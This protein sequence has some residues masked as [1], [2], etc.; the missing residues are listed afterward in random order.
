MRLHYALILAAA[1][2]FGGCTL[3]ASDAATVELSAAE[4][5]QTGDYGD[6]LPERDEVRRTVEL[7]PGS[8]VE[9]S[10][11]NG[12]VTVETSNSSTAE[13]HIVR[14][15]RSRDDL[16]RRRVLIDESPGFLKIHG[17]KDQ[18]RGPDVRQRVMLKV[19]RSIELTVRGINGRVGVGEI[20][21]MIHVSGING[22][23]EVAHAKSTSD[24]SGINGRVRI[25]LDRLHESGMKISG[26]NGRVELY[27]AEAVNADISV[28][29]INGSVRNESGAITVIGKITP[30]SFRG[31]IGEGGPEINVS[32]VNGNVDLLAG[33][34]Q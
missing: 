9:V 16:N 17:E 3:T 1:L 14:S 6:D 11:I 7:A 32:G 31:R 18:G 20:D 4:H 10:G 15:A 27:F 22:A 19:P 33:S 28:T 26:V 25:S 34:G 8:R 24:I 29:G 13:I 5:R 23:V 21:G 12:G 2:G 30:S